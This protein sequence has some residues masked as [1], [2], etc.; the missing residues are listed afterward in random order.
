MLT[1]MTIKGIHF[2]A[3]HGALEVERE[4]GQVLEIELSISYDVDPSSLDKD[5]MPP[6]MDASVYDIVQ[7][8]VMTTKFKAM[9]GLALEIARRIMLTYS[10]AELVSVVIRRRQL[11]IPGDVQSAEVEITV[12][13]EDLGEK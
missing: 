5:K 8:V 13:R 9:E 6:I 2:H 4:L 12:D 10:V 7:K 3:F 1:T 11:F